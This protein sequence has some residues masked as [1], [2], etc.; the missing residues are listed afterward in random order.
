MMSTMRKNTATI[1]WVLVFAF[2]ATIIFSWGMGGFKGRIEP[3]IVGKVNGVKITRDQYDEAIQNQFDQERQQSGNQ[4]VNSQRSEQIRSEV[5][6]TLVNNIILGQAQQKAGITVSDKE[7]ATAVRQMPPQAIVQ[8][9]SFRDS[10]GNFNWPL[11]RQVLNDPTYVNLVIQI[12]QETKQTLL[13]QKL[14]RRIAAFD[15]TSDDEA[16]NAWLRE[17]STVNAAYVLITARDMKAD[18]AGITDEKLHQLYEEKKDDFK[19]AESASIIY[20][21]MPDVPSRDDTTEARNLIERLVQRARNGEDFA[22][23]AKEYSEDASNADKGGD[24]GWFGRGRM[25]KPFDEAAFNAK[26]GQIVGPVLTQFGYHAILIKGSRTKDGEREINASHIL[27]KIE[28]SPETLDDLRTRA[29]GFQEEARQ[30]GF[31]EAAKVY[32]LQIDTVKRVMREGIDPVLGNNRAAREFL[33]NRPKGEISPAY[34]VRDGI[35]VFKSLK[36]TK[37]GYRSFDDVKMML[38]REVYYQLQ[39]EQ[40]GIVA[41]K[42][43]KKA[44]E[45]NNIGPALVDNNYRLTEVPREFTIDS[46]VPNVGRDYAFTAAAFALEPGTFSKPVK[47]ERG[48]YIILTRKKSVPDDAQWQSAKDEYI[49]QYSQKRQQAIFSQWIKVKRDEANIQDYRYLY[50]TQY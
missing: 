48:Y 37:A 50:Y 9:P 16:K 40:A 19:A 33:F 26:T 22:A 45:N 49:K 6:E 12:E 7:L 24:L 47:G 30:S 34:N 27:I 20:V 39:F 15:V 41:D 36:L 8:N 46:F 25:V 32:N 35:V 11:Y 18:S 5:W 28:R 4:E 29:E 42:I 43:Y 21:K 23:L 17:K 2:I 38:T 13:Q 1:L 3:G 31:E 10:L 14:L 44:K